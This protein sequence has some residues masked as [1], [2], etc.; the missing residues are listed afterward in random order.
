MKLNPG[1]KTADLWEGLVAQNYH[2]TN[3]WLQSITGAF[4]WKD[5]PQ[6]VL[7]NVRCDRLRVN[8]CAS[9]IDWSLIDISSKHLDRRR[10]LELRSACRQQHG[11]WIGFFSRSNTRHPRAYLRAT[12]LSAKSLSN[13]AWSAWNASWSRKKLVPLASRSCCSDMASSGCERRKAT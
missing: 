9:H 8:C 2:F 13:S 6:S 7:R 11:N 5:L 4:P 10:I 12:G 1:A 3:R